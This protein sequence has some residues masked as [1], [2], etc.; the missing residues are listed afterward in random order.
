MGNFFLILILKKIFLKALCIKRLSIKNNSLKYQKI[1][2]T[3]VLGRGGKSTNLPKII[4]TLY[5]TKK[6]NEAPLESGEIN[7]AF[8]DLTAKIEETRLEMLQKMDELASITALSTKK[9]L[10]VKDLCLLTGFKPAQIYRLTCYNQIPHYNLN[11][12]TLF[13]D[14]D[15]IDK[16]LKNNKIATNEEIRERATKYV[17]GGKGGEK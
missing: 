10:R 17:L 6:Y 8:Q 7:Q 15:E 16:W 3:F 9:V 5:M 12:K 2:C 13:F 14:R 4:K 1:S 11:G